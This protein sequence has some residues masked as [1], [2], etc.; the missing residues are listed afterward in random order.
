MNINKT[1]IHGFVH[2]QL[3]SLIA[4]DCVSVDFHIAWETI[5]TPIIAEHP[6]RDFFET[7]IAEKPPNI[8]G[9]TT[10]FE[11]R[12]VAGKEEEARQ[13]YEILHL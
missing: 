8:L 13:V 5:V 1:T 4:T 11:V 6:M 7:N 12:L 2:G 10:Y 9:E 3:E